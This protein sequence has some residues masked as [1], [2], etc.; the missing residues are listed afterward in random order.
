MSIEVQVGKHYE[1]YPLEWSAPIIVTLHAGA[2]LHAAESSSFSYGLDTDDL[3]MGSGPI[4]WCDAIIENTRDEMFLIMFWERDFAPPIPSWQNLQLTG[5]QSIDHLHLEHSSDV[6]PKAGKT[7]MLLLY[8]GWKAWRCR[9]Y[10]EK[11][12]I[13]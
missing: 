6:H 10:S 9:C 11:C 5:N 4:V 13:A 7:R 8:K 12:A 1:L 2:V 3:P